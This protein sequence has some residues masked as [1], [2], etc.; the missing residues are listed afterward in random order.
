MTTTATHP[1]PA[2]PAALPWMSAGARLTR[3]YL[4][5]RRVPAAAGLVAAL[6]C[7]LWAALQWH[8]NIAGGA[9][10]QLVIPLIV[11]TGA[12]AIIAVTSHGPF[13]EAERA[14]GR[15]LPWLRLGTALAL[16]AVAFGLLAAG[17][18]GGYLPGGSLALLR[19][20]GGM[21]GIGLLA[22]AVLGGSFGWTGPMGYLL[23]TE[24]ALA[25]GW[26]T[27]WIW[28]GRPAGDLGGALCAAAVFAAGLAAV[29]LLG[30]RR[31]DRGPASG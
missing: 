8:W 31:E 14:T 27:P 4:L 24:G 21:T 16:A 18:A 3:L 17:G 26:T 29:T 11:E 9:A 20:F 30:T 2:A 23:I 22:A 1:S 25:G 28:P 10:A 5:S 6:G 19:N 7:L 12:A 13:G 15:W